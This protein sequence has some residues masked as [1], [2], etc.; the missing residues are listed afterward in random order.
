MS[1]NKGFTLIETIIA[2]II[3]ALVGSM[4][5]SF[6]G[7]ALQKSAVPA[8]R[9]ARFYEKNQISDNIKAD[10]MADYLHQFAGALQDFADD[11]NNSG[12][13]NTANAT[14]S[15]VFIEY[16]QDFNQSIDN[17]GSEGILKVTVTPGAGSENLTTTFLLTE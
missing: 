10:Y 8:I 11:I 14:V 15:A 12:K 1:N 4:L 9:M 17:D 5:V 3:A 2:I 13:Y 16:D 7:T 6:T